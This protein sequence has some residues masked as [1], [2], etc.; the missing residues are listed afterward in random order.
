MLSRLRSEA[1]LDGS[2]RTQDAARESSVDSTAP[3]VTNA[4][5]RAIDVGSF[6]ANA[7]LHFVSGDS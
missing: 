5:H 1:T 2:A 4:L 6:L 7:V 3:A